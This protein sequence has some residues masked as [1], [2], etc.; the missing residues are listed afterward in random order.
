MSSLK[1]SYQQVDGAQAVTESNRLQQQLQALWALEKTGLDQIGFP[2]RVAKMLEVGCGNGA[3]LSQVR[4][5]FSP[6]FAVGIDLELE[7]LLRAKTTA[8]VARADGGVLPFRDA[9]FDLVMF[10]Y[11]LRHVPG[12]QRLLLEATRVLKPGGRLLA[13]DSD[14][15]GLLFDPPPPSWPALS[16]ALD[17]SVRRRG[18]NPHM[19]RTLHRQLCEAGLANVVTSAQMI[20]SSQVPPP[21]FVEL[22]LAPQARPVDADLLEPAAAQQAWNELRQWAKQSQAFCCALGMFA[23]GTKR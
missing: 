4:R 15:G 17:V 10:R 13:L 21:V 8:V 2:P 14:D 20:T 9:T 7:H 3:V 11:V 1:G 6:G 5:D 12:P 19:G 18:G 23:G 16:N 22:L